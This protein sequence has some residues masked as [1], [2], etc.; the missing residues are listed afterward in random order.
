MLQR[1]HNNG[2]ELLEEAVDA[3]ILFYLAKK[4]DY[5]RL[6]KIVEC[7][8]VEGYPSPWT[9]RDDM[10]HTLLHWA[11]LWGHTE[12]VTAGVREIDP[13]SRPDNGQTVL[14]WA[15]IRGHIDTMNA[16]IA[17]R[18]DLL[19]KDCLGATPFT[20]AIQHKQFAAVLVL[21]RRGTTA[22]IDDCDI[23]GCTPLH[24]AAYK[25][26]I[27]SLR[28]LLGYYGTRANPIDNSGMTPLHRAVRSCQLEAIAYL[29]EAKADQ[30]I[31]D[32]KG[33]TP[34][35]MA[36]EFKDD[37][38]WPHIVRLLKNR[39]AS[40]N[41]DI[42]AALHD[43]GEDDNKKRG[44]VVESFKRM[45]NSPSAQKAFPLFW[46]I[47]V[48]LAFV[49]YVID[50]RPQSHDVAPRVSKLFEYAV[51]LSLIFFVVVA[52]KDPGKVKPGTGNHSGV[53]Q[54]QKALAGEGKT[55]IAD[56]VSD[57]KRLC[58]T[59]WVVKGF[60]TKYCTQT[61]S[62]IEE[63]DHYCV[64]L[65]CSIGRGNHRQFILLS[66]IEMFTQL[67]HVYLLWYVGTTVVEYTGFGSYIYNIAAGYP[68]LFP[69]L[70]IHLLTIPWVLMLIVHQCRLIAMNL[71]TNEMLN[72]HRY[73]HF[74]EISEDGCLRSLG[75]FHNPFDKGSW[76]K[77][78]LDFWWRRRR[79]EMRSREHSHCASHECCKS[80]TK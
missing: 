40:P 75:N 20:I 80:H 48:F 38:T 52:K 7:K 24:W 8:P 64:W 61:K 14:M 44:R 57:C 70:I 68:L 59:T 21:L 19:A 42:E 1:G 27:K 25:G 73:E 26:D 3:N 30:Q 56:A 13:D 74:W 31:R 35:E 16:I 4:G 41:M 37:C 67:F 51:P 12:F 76:W 2:T 39:L 32:D 54:L 53:E 55:D 9:V 45:C 46:L 69:I 77:N 65:N 34:L 50:L 18:A 5:H 58:T 23:N 47:C 49:Q 79:S 15:V 33:K 28:L 22:V 66:I 63:F 72:L 60:R 43:G 62:C 29:L 11:A 6:I 10:G 17:A 36:E 71:T 78:T